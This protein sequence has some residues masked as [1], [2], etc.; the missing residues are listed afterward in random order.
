M[1][2]SQ[3]LALKTP[4][5]LEALFLTLSGEE[6]TVKV[7]YNRLSW[8]QTRCQSPSRRHGPPPATAGSAPGRRNAGWRFHNEPF[9][10]LPAQ[11]AVRL[12]K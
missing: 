11:A 12:K 2:S 6:L 9:Y 7:A 8:G 5:R 4:K 1:A 10:C 3:N